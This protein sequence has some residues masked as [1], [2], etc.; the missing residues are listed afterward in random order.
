M[1]F[2][3]LLMFVIMVVVMLPHLNPPASSAEQL[4]DPPGNLVV[5]IT[6]PEGT[7][8][9][10]LWTLGPGEPGAVGY[11]NKGGKLWNLL[12]DDLG[13]TTDFL[14]GNF[15]NAFSRG[16]PDG[17]YWVNL[18]CYRCSV[19]PV[20]V[21]VEISIKSKGGDGVLRITKIFN[22]EVVLDYSGEEVTVISFR[23]DKNK[24]LRGSLNHLYKPLRTASK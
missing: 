19:L 11:S 5:N 20:P 21:K 24:L 13:L 6:W 12:R 1:L 15:E 3:A 7:N 2:L 17:R 9:V 18:H 10:D 22:T 16:V 14:P 23:M 4:T 8:D